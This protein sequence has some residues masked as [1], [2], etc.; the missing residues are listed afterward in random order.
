MQYLLVA[1]LLTTNLTPLEQ[2][3]QDYLKRYPLERQ[4]RQLEREHR[5]MQLR[6]FETRIQRLENCTKLG[7]C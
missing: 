5:E 1:M 2:A 7:I 4:Q 6:D 3:A